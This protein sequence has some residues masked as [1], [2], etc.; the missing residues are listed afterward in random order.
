M[1]ILYFLSATLACADVGLVFLGVVGHELP[2]TYAGVWVLIT[3]ATMELGLYATGV[4]DP[5]AKAADRL[6]RDLEDEGDDA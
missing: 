2:A 6:L 4:D 1:P 5:P 3:W